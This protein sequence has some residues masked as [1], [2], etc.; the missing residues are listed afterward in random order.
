MVQRSGTCVVS[1]AA[2][3]KIGQPD[4]AEKDGVPLYAAIDDIDLSQH[5]LAFPLLLEIAA[6][7]VNGPTALC[8]AFDREQL[9]KLEEVGFRLKWSLVPGGP[10][11]G[12]LGYILE[13]FAS[14][15]SKFNAFQV[16]WH[17][18]IFTLVVDTGCVQLIID[19]KVHVSCQF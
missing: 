12:F 14:G 3:E 17:S 15:T 19:R 7:P 16:R 11:V 6:D 4:Y 5:S 9:E 18:D 13:K 10:E 1:N 8:K 2:N